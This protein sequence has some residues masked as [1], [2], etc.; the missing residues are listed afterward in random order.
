MRLRVVLT[1]V[2]RYRTI[3]FRAGSACRYTKLVR[4]LAQDRVAH[5]TDRMK[6][7]EERA[8]DRRRE[9]EVRRKLS[10]FL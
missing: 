9:L 7:D 2:V 5:A 8:Y 1:F 10:S 4:G 3:A 6:T